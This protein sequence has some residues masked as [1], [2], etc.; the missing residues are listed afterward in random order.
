MAT[1]K[2]YELDEI[3]GPFYCPREG[4]DMRLF[5]IVSADFKLSNGE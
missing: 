3:E 4:G 5:V 1:D 2:A